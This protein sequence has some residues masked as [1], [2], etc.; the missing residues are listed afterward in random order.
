MSNFEQ[1]CFRRK[2]IALLVTGCFMVTSQASAVEEQSQDNCSG[3]AKT[4]GTFAGGLLGGLVGKQLGDGKAGAIVAGVVLGGFLG[5]YIGSEIDRRHCELE[6]IAKA[7]G[8]EIKTE[9]LELKDDTG[10]SLTTD[11]S[12][13]ESSG[14]NIQATISTG[15][16]DVVRLPGAG[17]FALGSATLTDEAKKYF[18]EAAKQYSAEN[19]SDAAIQSRVNEVAQ[20]GQ[21]LSEIDKQKL[22]KQYIEELN[23]RPIVMVGHTDD[24]GDSLLN[25]QLSEKRARVVADLFKSK[26]IPASRIYFRGAGDSDP[27]ADNRKEEG[28]AVNRRVEFIELESVEKLNTF[29]ALKKENTNYLRPKKTMTVDQTV[30]EAVNDNVASQSDGSN[31]SKASGEAKEVKAKVTDLTLVKTVLDFGGSQSNGNI[32]TAIRE[33][34]GKAI[35]PEKSAMDSIGGWFV[36]EAKADESKVYDLPCTA[37]APRYGGQ[38]VSLQTGKTV[39]ADTKT[40]DYAPGL[41]Q[42]S[43]VGVVNGNYLGITPVGVLRANFQPASHPSLLVYANTIV[44]G[45]DAKP[46]MK[47]PMQ[48]NVYPGEKGILYRMYATGSTSLVCADLILPRRAPFTASAGKL[49][50]K[51]SGQT[52]E[53]DYMPSIL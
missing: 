48:V 46:S 20:Q 19:A 39:G 10:K 40:A 16:V 31:K 47:I 15:K 37:D 25:Q 32:N 53:N 36:K 17:H 14:G 24:T 33:A 34:M 18:A 11:D 35:E 2:T 9:E 21:Q 27:V 5:N 28:R 3:K 6:K 8:L 50:Y 23:R 29:I 26:G 52:F 12:S 44:P 13:Q 42:T 4:I 38:Y 51:H 45:A 30:V 41:Y 49:Y 7:N 43:W 22:R 1:V